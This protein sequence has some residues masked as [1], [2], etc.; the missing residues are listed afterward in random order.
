[1]KVSDKNERSRGGVHRHQHLA[2]VRELSGVL[3]GV[4]LFAVL[5]FANL[6]A[7]TLAQSPSCPGI[8]VKI[9]GIRNSNGIV[10]CALFDAPVG[11]PTEFLHSAS[12]V[13]VLRVRDEQARCNFED[14]PPGT[15]ALAVIHDENSDGKL[16]TN[17]LGIPTEGYGFSNDAKG[18]LGPP[19]FLA[20]SFS[21][22][23]RSVELT[24]A[25]ITEA[26]CRTRPFRMVFSIA[27][28]RS[29]MI[30]SS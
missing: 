4:A 26:H 28:I 8:H 23:G 17:L 16:N 13:M 27:G 24:T 2:P 22:D 20:A 18:L 10:D 29:W 9:L 7:P 3:V 1:M 12:R 14:I 6:P 25:C 19:T 21:Y 15:H 30:E 11:F 5:T